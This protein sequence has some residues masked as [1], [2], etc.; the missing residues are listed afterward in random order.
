MRKSIVQTLRSE[1]AR[2]VQLP[3]EEIDISAHLATQGVDSLQ[4]LQLIVLLERTYKIEIP[5][6]ELKRF[7]SINAVADLVESRLEVSAV[8]TA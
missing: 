8:A 2:M 4:A 5:E 3:E 6:E 1:V 7:T